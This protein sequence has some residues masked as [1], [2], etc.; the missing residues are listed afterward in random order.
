MTRTKIFIVEDEALVATDL[1]RCLTD[2]GYD[3]VGIA[4]TGAD[5]VRQTRALQPDLVLMDIHLKDSLDG[6]A[7]AGQIRANVRRPPA[8]VFLTSHADDDTV[9]RVGA[10]EPFGYVVKPY[11]T[12]ALRAAI[13]TA[14]YRRAA[15]DRLRQMEQ[16]LA[17][18]LRSIGDAVLATDAAGRISY[19][20]PIGEALTG[21]TFFEALGRPYAEVFQ[22]VHEETGQPALDPVPQAIAQGIVIN[23]AERT[24]LVTKRGERLPIDDSVAPIR[25]EDGHITG[26]V[27]VFRDRSDRKRLEEERSRIERKLQESQRLESLGVLSAGIAHD[28]NNI[29]SVILGNAEMCRLDGTKEPRL[30]NY[31]SE[32]ATASQRAADLCSQMLAYAGKSATIIKPLDLGALATDTAHLLRLSV[33][34]MA[35]L[36]VNLTPNLPWIA[37]DHRQ[38]QQVIMNLVINASEAIGERPGEITLTT[39]RLRPQAADWVGTLLS[40]EEVAPEYVCLELR[41][42]GCGMSPDTLA[43]I[44]DPFFTTKFLGR[45]LG[46]A[47]VLGIVRS[48]GGVLKV[49]SE[50]GRGTTFQVWLPPVAKPAAPVTPAAPASSDWRGSGRVLVVD[51][52]EPVRKVNRRVLE[53][54]GFEVIEAANGLEAI[55]VCRERGDQ[56]CAVILD[57]TMPQ[58][59]GL[60]AVQEILLLQSQLPMLL[61]S[62]YPEH[63]AK[64]QSAVTDRI[65]F[66]S[67]PYSLDQFKAALQKILG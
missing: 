55:T 17:T 42:T 39:G 54:F 13:E 36:K 44:F 51:D 50:L 6:V 57:Q 10:T 2:L 27:V 37:G 24:S 45:G 7:A 20:N 11:E 25:D 21:W 15:E 8:V 56:L 28:F 64:A 5:A 60:E 30:Q 47:A 1:N 34:K 59:S 43:K 33:S 38:L 22:L 31:L 46:L 49:T 18:T 26:V 3:V 4:D 14:C 63:A 48:H 40:P 12:R 9:A 61:I 41:D 58:K 19:L 16:W 67:K 35:E 66:L 65:A 32:I 52:E 29:L 23:L 53:R 62:G